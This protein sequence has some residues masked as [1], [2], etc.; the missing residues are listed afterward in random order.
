M[1]LQGVDYDNGLGHSRHYG[2]NK[3]VT[4]S[5][6][7]VAGFVSVL[8][9]CPRAHFTRVVSQSPVH[10]LLKASVAAAMAVC[11]TI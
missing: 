4:V 3:P 7:G 8:V 6:I 9:D 1:Y 11:E 5:P 10:P 2:A